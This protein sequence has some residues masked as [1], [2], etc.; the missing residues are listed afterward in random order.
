MKKLIAFICLITLIITIASGCG[1]DNAALKEIKDKGTI[2]VG[3]KTDVPGFGYYNSETKEFEGLEIDLARL[4]AGDILGD[5][6]AVEFTGVTAQ[7]RGPMLENGELDMV[8]AT[9]TI[10]E[11]RKKSYNFTQPYFHDEIGFLVKVDSD[12][13]KIEDIDGKTIGI[14]QSGTAKDALVAES[15]KLGI[16][17]NFSERASYPELKAALIAGEIDAFS[18]DKSILIGYS[19]AQTRI[20]D[21]GFNPQ[22]YGIATKLEN[23]Q[24]AEHLDGFL[25]SIMEDGQF[26]EILDRWERNQ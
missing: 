21:D 4:I 3:V 14:A 23:T 18:V 22:D 8:I 2:R 13:K 20:L 25:G 1:N 16:S 12:M 9:F 5:E 7:T 24:L 11:E 19:D 10:T 15:E 26:D 17:L 6:N